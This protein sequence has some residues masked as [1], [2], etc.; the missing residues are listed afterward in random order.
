MH[1]ALGDHLPVK[2]SEFLDQLDILEQCRSS[3]PGRRGI[4]VVG[5]GSPCNVGQL[6][7]NCFH[8]L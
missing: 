8:P 7:L 3:F 2:M 1:A 5:D 4:L 6:L